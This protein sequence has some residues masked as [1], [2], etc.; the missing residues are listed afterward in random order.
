MK[1]ELI[2]FD[3]DGTILNTL[4]DL[5]DSTNYA[6]AANGLRERTIEEVRN[7]VG[8]GIRTLIQRAVGEEYEET[9]VDQVFA[10][11]CEYYS[12]HCA[13]KTRPYD[14][15]PELLTELHKG[16]YHLAVVSNKADFAV[17]ELCGKYFPGMFEYVVGE[18]KGIRRKPYP[19]SVLEV[20]RT[21]QVSKEA[22]VYVGDSEV[23]IQTAEQAGIEVICAEWGFRSRA[24]LTQQGGKNFAASPMEIYRYLENRAE[25]RVNL[26]EG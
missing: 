24:Y 18:R 9:V 6:L 4:D 8:N 26:T 16:G 10:D 22:T 7:F 1:K 17:Q 19:D 11:F 21:L 3:L 20:L 13:D 23:D 12:R 5:T 2:I 15:I 25:K 14:K